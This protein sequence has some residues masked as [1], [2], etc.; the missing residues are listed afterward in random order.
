MDPS[1]SPPGPHPSFSPQALTPA[2]PPGTSGLRTSPQ[3]AQ[4]A[5]LMEIRSRHLSGD[6]CPRPPQLPV[7]G[8]R[9][10]PGASRGWASFPRHSASRGVP[11]SLQL[12]AALTHR[13]R[14]FHLMPL[15]PRPDPTRVT[16]VVDDLTHCGNSPAGLGPRAHSKGSLRN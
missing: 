16:S 11:G 9:G 3:A 12:R 14:S 8:A 5:S 15:S 1:F 6:R 2:S 7:L 10:P 4:A 13:A